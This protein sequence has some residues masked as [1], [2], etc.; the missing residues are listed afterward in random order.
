M[1]RKFDYTDMM[2][3][4]RRKFRVWWPCP[5]NL[6]SHFLSKGPPNHSGLL[7]SKRMEEQH[8]R[9]EK[10]AANFSLFS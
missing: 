7:S 4:M 1:R 6:T 5:P 10:K 2:R 3:L 8:I 9:R